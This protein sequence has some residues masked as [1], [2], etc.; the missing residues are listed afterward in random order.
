MKFNSSQTT[1]WA[2]VGVAIVCA[3]AIGAIIAILV[4]HPFP[5]DDLSSGS[6]A[7][8]ISVIAQPFDDSREV[9]ITIE[10]GPDRA[11]LSQASGLVTALNCTVGSSIANGSSPV[12]VDGLPRLGLATTIPMWRDLPRGAR[13]SDVTSLQAAL[14]QLGYDV[15]SDGQVVGPAT[16]AAFADA[17]ANIGSGTSNRNTIWLHL[18][19]WIPD[20]GAKVAGCTATVGQQVAPGSALAVFAPGLVGA[21]ITKIPDFLIPGTRVLEL[22]GNEIPVDE[23]G[24]IT[25]GE[26]LAKLADSA[27]YAKAAADSN[28]PGIPATYRLV[29]KVAVAVVPPTAVIGSP[30]N[31]CVVSGETAIG[32]T[33]VGSQ[34]GQTFVTFEGDVPTA[35]AIKPSAGA[36]CK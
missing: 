17:L 8:E 4:F 11:L 7:T 3:I 25:D 26:S 22:S 20:A 5:P 31:Q 19:V 32:V 23:S 18:L 6:T 33:V 35:V 28:N 2:T 24:V 14:T 36:K 10:R 1:R 9:Q 29:E 34:L 21:H 15:A 13:G 30:E 27:E 16:L 12:A